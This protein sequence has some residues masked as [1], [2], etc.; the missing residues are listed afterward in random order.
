[1]RGESPPL[2]RRAFDDLGGVGRFIAPAFHG[3]TWAFDDLGGVGRFIAPA[4]HGST[5]GNAGDFTTAFFT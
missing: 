3:S 1:V 4:F 2:V 5:W